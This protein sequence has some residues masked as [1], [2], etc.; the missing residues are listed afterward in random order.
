M[1]SHD[2]SLWAVAPASDKGYGVASENAENTEQKRKQR[3]NLLFPSFAF[4]CVL[5][6]LR[7]RL[8]F[9]AL[10]QEPACLTPFW[11]RV[12]S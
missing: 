11:K 6:D 8:V 3:G 7:V 9:S 1:A 2:R 10:M 4:F 5:R 12:Q